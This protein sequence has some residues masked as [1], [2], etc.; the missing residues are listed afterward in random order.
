[1]E[2]VVT[3]KGYHSGDTMRDM[4]EIQ[5]RTYVSEPDRGRRR[6][7][8]KA[9]EQV[10]VYANR[11]RIRGRRGKELLRKRGELLE[12]TFAH[13]YETGGMRRVHLRGHPNILKR[14]LIHAAAGNLGLL[15]RK[16]LGWG[17]PRGLR[18]AVVADCRVCLGLAR[19]LI[20]R[21][22]R[23]LA[24]LL[25]HAWSFGS[26]SCSTVASPAAS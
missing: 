24:R 23:H 9:E 17:T 26:H 22:A 20:A 10:A 5:V 18:R 13:L 21:A 2:E 12:R 11:R 16:V 1:M 19:T 7:K 3:D 14:L 6:W 15:M 25:A 4:A 8:G